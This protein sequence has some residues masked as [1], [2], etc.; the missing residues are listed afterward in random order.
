M[1]GTS[2]VESAFKSPSASY[3]PS[4]RRQRWCL[5]CPDRGYLRDLTN[6]PIDST[7]EE[8]TADASAAYQYVTVQAAWRALDA[9]AG[10]Y[11]DIHVTLVQ[12]VYRGNGV[13]TPA[14]DVN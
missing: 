6:V 7:V 10:A 4:P 2:A 13:W 8:Y 5:L 3:N 14:A 12:F 1:P 11:P 9:T